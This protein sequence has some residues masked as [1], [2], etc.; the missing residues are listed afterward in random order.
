[1]ARRRARTWR[2]FLLE[3]GLIALLI[4]AFVNFAEPF[5]RWFGEYMGDAMERQLEPSGSP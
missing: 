3:L 4:L 5:G 1:M 2:G